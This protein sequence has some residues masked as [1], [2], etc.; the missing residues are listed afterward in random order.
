[1]PKTLAALIA[2]LLAG[3]VLGFD[4]HTVT[5]GPL[6]LAIGEVGA[7]AEYDT[8]CAV[9]VTLRNTGADALSVR[10]ALSGL[11][12]EW[13]PEGRTEAAAEV[14]AGDTATVAF[15]IAA[16]PGAPSALYPVRV[17]ATFG[18]GQGQTTLEA[19]RVFEARFRRASPDARPP[20]QLPV[21]SVPDRGALP[22][23]ALAGHRAVWRHFGAE[24]VRKPVGWRGSDE[25]SRATFG[26]SRADRG[27]VR[28]A[29]VMHPPYRE[30]KGTVFAEYRLRLPATTPLRL[31]FAN[32]IRDHHGSEPASDGVTFRVWADGEK[33]FERHTASKV[34]LDGR[35]DLSPWAGRE[36]RLRLESH[37]G[38]EHNTVCD[39]SFWAEPTVVA[40]P[41]PPR[42]RADEKRTLARR[43]RTAVADPRDP[44]RPGT[45]VFDL[46]G[47]CAAA[48]VPGPN[49]LADAAL[50]FGRG[51]RVV[52]LDGMRLEVLDAEVGA[53]PPQVTVR[54]VETVRDSR[55]GRLRIVHRCR[56]RGEAFALTAEVWA[57]GPGLRVRL[58]C[59]R[60]LTDLASGPADRKAPCVYF[61][62]GYRVVEPE[63]FRA[64]AGGH[65]LSTSHVGFDFAG[66]PSL[67]VATDHGP[68]TLRVD[69]ARRVY[70]LHAREDTTFTFV[71]SAAG[72]M[73]AAVRYRSICPLRAAPG[74]ARKAGR[75]VFDIWGGR[76]ARNLDAM[77]RAFAYG[78][79]DSMLI[80]HVW[81][82]WGYDYRLPDIYPP[83]PDLGTLEDLQR[84]GRLCR[85]HG[86]PWGLHDNYIDFYPDAADYSYERICF[87]AAGRPV[88]AWINQ[89]RDAQ[90]YRWRPD[91]FAPFLERNL[92]R[93]GPALR[94][95]AYFV[96]VFA[97]MGGF[98][99]YDKRGGFHP[100]SETLRC[101]GRAFDSIREYLGGNALT[102]SEAGGD[103]L[104]GHLDGADCQHLQLAP[105]H[106]WHYVYLP[107]KD[108]Q[109]VPWFDAVNHRRF[110]LHGV[111]YSGR[112][113]GRRS[114]RQHGIESDDYLSAEMLLG[115][116]LMIDR[117]G[118]VRGAVR[119]YWL[120][121]DLIRRLATDTI[122]RVDFAGGDADRQVV[123]WASGAVVCVNRGQTDWRVRGHRLPPYGYYGRSGRVESCIERID[124]VIVEWSRG[125]DRFYVNGRG[126][127]TDPPL[128]IRPSVGD[129]AYL[130]GREFKLPIHW[131]AREPTPTDLHVFVH[132]VMPPRSRLRQHRFY[133]G[134]NPKP[135][136]SQWQGR[137]STGG[138]RVNTVPDDCPPGRYDV[139]VGLWDP[140]S[141]RRRRLLGEE[142]DDKRFRVGTIVV[143]GRGDRVTRIRLEGPTS[144]DPADTYRRNRGRRPIDFGSAVTA[145]AFRCERAGRN[146]LVLT[147]LPEEEPADLT[148][149][150]GALG[151][152][153]AV[154]REGLAVDADGRKTGKV[155]F[156]ARADELTFRTRRGEFAYQIVTESP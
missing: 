90:S 46:A 77:K 85:E 86:V 148:L 73:D 67:L 75:F 26:R 137:V 62:H 132:F 117:Q 30:G 113:Q 120:G 84:L 91:A 36:I 95:T 31:L 109:R 146:R 61:G 102:V 145:G 19:V 33:V 105:A 16:G 147:P 79:T 87:D 5:E 32:A 9:P 114:R 51:D 88:K 17:R 112:Y 111:G 142:L 25:V 131:D 38:P 128:R 6:T 28:D 153:D 106:L 101:W 10:V 12:D 154:V 50:A 151:E 115:H 98:D 4:G 68:D 156:E 149:R 122:E 34:W 133:T 124:G 66:G 58:T 103:H 139:L 78:L 80:L 55:A 47:A 116:A 53:W 129:L 92:K 143:E 72:A 140:K 14:A 130:G 22:L 57:E 11:V 135:P 104:I 70:A 27:E 40:G 74:V 82:R 15:R 150:L 93:I 23:L 83:N 29:L 108:W 56:L 97:S 48:V 155:P 89:G 3:P 20:D 121:Q 7:A 127:D 99:Y 100:K 144:A 43:A 52:V 141:R 42:R 65:N 2:V 81:Q 60:R 18:G 138:N 152:K 119:K 21:E 49:G 96:D 59:P 45:F 63:A 136:T 8:P 44:P 123:S 35:A 41:L 107:C 13:R 71:P 39:S 1:M 64:H 54:E 69:P 125:P 76:Y 94:P 24:P 37:P 118:M 126:T 110:S 134:S